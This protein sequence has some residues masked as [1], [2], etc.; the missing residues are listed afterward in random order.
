MSITVQA[1]K[2]DEPVIEALDDS[3]VLVCSSSEE[4][5]SEKNSNVSGPRAPRMIA[6]GRARTHVLDGAPEDV[7]R[8][9]IDHFLQ[10]ETPLETAEI[11]G[12]YARISKA[13]NAEMIADRQRPENAWLSKVRSAALIPAMAHRASREKH[14]Q[15]KLAAGIDELVKTHAQLVLPLSAL[16]EK[17][18][19][20]TVLYRVMVAEAPKDIVI[21]YSAPASVWKQKHPDY[22]PFYSSRGSWRHQQT[23]LKLMQSIPRADK[24]ELRIDLL[25]CNRLVEPMVLQTLMKAGDKVL[26]TVRKL[27]LSGLVISRVEDEYRLSVEFSM[28]LTAKT[29]QNLPTLEEFRL[30]D[31]VIDS[32]M[33]QL[34]CPGLNGHQRMKVLALGGN[35]LCRDFGANQKNLLGWTALMAEITGMPALRELDLSRN[36]VGDEAADMLLTTLKLIKK[37]EKTLEKVDLRGNHIRKDHPI[38]LDERVIGD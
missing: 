13:H 17:S 3:D 25:L 6:G 20:V 24:R 33:L 12:L 16:K 23:L 35:L 38:W 34:L 4:S 9:F 28:K 22:M 2:P 11:R 7:H 32:S 37:G 15:T 10:G 18:A 31:S 8:Y 5:S 19:Q 26:R 29:L 1:V 30:C 21:D 36:K 27:D 14:A